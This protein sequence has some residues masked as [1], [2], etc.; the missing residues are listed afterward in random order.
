MTKTIAA[1]LAS[2][3]IARANC[4]TA[5]NAEW[6]ARHT[7]RILDF[8]DN[9]LPSGSG[10]D[11]GTDIDLQKSTAEKLVLTG[12][13]H[14]M[15]AHGGYDGWTDHTI[16]VRP[17]FVYGVKLTISGRDRND[18]KEHIYSLFEIALNAPATR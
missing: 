6:E 9:H 8:A 11:L 14:H 7:M 5:G 1:E 13:F 17:S 16:T 3:L 10:W 4:I 12:S 2:L 15:D 18:I